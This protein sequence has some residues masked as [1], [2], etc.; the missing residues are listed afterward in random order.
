MCWV[1]PLPGNYFHGRAG[2]Y[3]ET[4]ECAGTYQG[5]IFISK[6]LVG[7]CRSLSGNCLQERANPCLDTTCVSVPAPIWELLQRAGP[8]PETTYKS[9][10]ARRPFSVNYL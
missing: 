5:S 9:A 3:P 7:K 10:A 4:N 8:Y 2:S 6:Q 1:L